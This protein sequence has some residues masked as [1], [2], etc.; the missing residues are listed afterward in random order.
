MAEGKKE[1]DEIAEKKRSEFYPYLLS[2]LLPHPPG[3]FIPPANNL[4]NALANQF[5]RNPLHTESCLVLLLLI[6]HIYKINIM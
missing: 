1:C 3:L 6:N 4:K 5:S 2:N